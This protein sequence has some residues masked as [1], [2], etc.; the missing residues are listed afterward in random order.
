MQGPELLFRSVGLRVKRLYT[1]E[2]LHL[3]FKIPGRFDDINVFPRTETADADVEQ[4]LRGGR[5]QSRG[6][7][8]LEGAQIE[9]VDAEGFIDVGHE[10]RG[11]GVGDCEVLEEKPGGSG[12]VKVGLQHAGVEEIVEEAAREAVEGEEEGFEEGGAQGEGAAVVAEEVFGER[13]GFGD[14]V[15]EGFDGLLDV[16]VEPGVFG[17]AEVADWGAGFGGVG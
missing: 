8:L 17:G 15:G 4:G 5:V 16:Q 12:S 2:F 7:A 13:D 6:R 14:W 3:G 1:A 10:V 9:G 11:G